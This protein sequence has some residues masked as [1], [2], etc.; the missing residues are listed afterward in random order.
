MVSPG[1]RITSTAR[2]P[3]RAEARNSGRGRKMPRDD[4]G[5]CWAYGSVWLIDG[6]KYGLMIDIVV[7]I[8]YGW[9]IELCIWIF[10]CVYIY[11]CVT[12]LDIIN[13]DVARTS[14]R[15]GFWAFWRLIDPADPAD[16]AVHLG[17]KI[18][19]G[20]FHSSQ[21]K[22]WTKTMW[23]NRNNKPSYNIIHALYII[24]KRIIDINYTQ[25]TS[26]P[27]LPLNGSALHSAAPEYRWAPTVW[28]ACGHRSAWATRVSWW[29]RCAVE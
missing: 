12:R 8:M 28:S 11:I 1:S 9:Y 23:V 29:D 6:K 22:T 16:P 10:Q 24:Y 26:V 2:V 20:S 4:G 7:D 25:Q 19:W 17:N 27:N 21:I 13:L 5:R 18:R 15:S 3:T 14:F